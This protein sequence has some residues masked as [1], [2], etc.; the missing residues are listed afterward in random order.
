[1]S[2][3]GFGD[4]D[5]EGFN[6][7]PCC[8]AIYTYGGIEEPGGFDPECAVHG[9][10]PEQRVWHE[11]RRRVFEKTGDHTF[12]TESVNTIPDPVVEIINAM[13]VEEWKRAYDQGIADERTAEAQQVD[14]GVGIPAQADRN[15]PHTERGLGWPPGRP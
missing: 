12:A 8:G 13:F 3:D 9:A 5:P 7:Y 10:T 1:M 11:I 4:I 15:N 6:R 2:H 14:V